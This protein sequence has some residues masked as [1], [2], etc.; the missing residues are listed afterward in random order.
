MIH[1]FLAG[2]AAFLFLVLT[3]PILFVLWLIGKNDPYKRDNIA[4]KMVR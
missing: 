1:L 2:M 4:F 3:L